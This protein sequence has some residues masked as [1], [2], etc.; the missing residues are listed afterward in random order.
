[1]ENVLCI[2]IERPQGKEFDLLKY[3]EEITNTRTS[4]RVVWKRKLAL[5]LERKK[6]KNQQYENHKQRKRQDNDLYDL[7]N[8]N[9]DEKYGSSKK[10]CM[11]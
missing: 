4:S 11:R 9:E 2:Y 7:D 3:E 1:M 8:F 10:L 6:E 5:V